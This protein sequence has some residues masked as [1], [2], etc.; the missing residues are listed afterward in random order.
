MSSASSG[1]RTRRFTNAWKL[2]RRSRRFWSAPDVLTEGV[3]RGGEPPR[4]L[5]FSSMGYRDA[6]S[7]GNRSPGS[8]DKGKSR[9]SLRSSFRD[10][11]I[12]TVIG[13]TDGAEKHYSLRRA[14]V[15]SAADGLDDALGAEAGL[16]LGE[17]VSDFALRAGLIPNPVD[18]AGDSLLY[19]DGGFVA[20]VLGAGDVGDEGATFA[21]A[22]LAARE[23]LDADVQL[24][25]N[26][27]GEIA[28]GGRAA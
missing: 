18:V 7:P 27:A 9:Y 6:G 26:D 25:G 2:A 20:D 16:N 23:R 8:R 24:V 21:G 14:G 1:S 3:S 11:L 13:E 22:E 28:H 10:H 19:G 15:I 4:D 12:A 5:G 17:V